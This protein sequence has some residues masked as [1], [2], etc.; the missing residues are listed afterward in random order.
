MTELVLS[1]DRPNCPGKLHG[2]PAHASHLQ[3]AAR[4]LGWSRYPDLCP[5]CVRLEAAKVA[6]LEAATNDVA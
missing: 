5:A 1:C 4:K 3:I 2:D 6:F